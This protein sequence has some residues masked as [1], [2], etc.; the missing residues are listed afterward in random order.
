MRG[1]WLG[2]LM[3]VACE[4]RLSVADAPTC[5]AC[6]GCCD[7]GRC[8][9]LSQQDST[10]C[11]TT[12]P[13]QPCSGRCVAGFCKPASTCGTCA[14]CC[15]DTFCLDGTSSVACGTNADACQRCSIQ[16]RCIQGV[17]QAC[18]PATCN[19]C[20]V[21]GLCESGTTDVRCGRGGVECQL[22]SGATSCQSGVCR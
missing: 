1:W 10:F 7:F 17:C 2:L 12:G 21:L 20:C 9:P 6:D 8:V 5:S 11:G 4:T 15:E 22:C 16:Q 18:S 13:C 3:L 19:G 14:G